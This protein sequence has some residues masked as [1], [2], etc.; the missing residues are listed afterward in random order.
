M[1]RIALPNKGS[2]SEATVNM[3]SEAGYHCRRS[4]RELMLTD[5]ENELEFIFLRPRDIAIYVNSGILDLGITGRDLYLDSETSVHELLSLGF[6][7]STFRYAI[8]TA[9]TL[10]P[11][12]FHGLRI[13]TSYPNLVRQDMKR[14]SVDT[15]VIELDG[16]VEISI[17]LGVAD[18][19]ADVVE[20]GRTLKE[21]GLKVVGEPV[22]KSEAVV[23]ARAQKTEQDDQVQTF[24]KR[25]QGI[26]VAR[27][28]VM[29][30]YDIPRNLLEKGC[31][32]TPGIESPT[33]APLNDPKWI[34]VKAMSLRKGI[35]N[36]MDQLADLGAKGILVT[37]IRTCRI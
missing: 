5:L 29:I 23:I 7:K 27:D 13:A 37:E 24:L 19:I 15:S 36:I 11:D 18:A 10:T 2:L 21:A 16:A 32:I 8:P 1:L 9:S 35:N 4:S 31:L 33:I 26:V 3:L 28:Y 17:R 34:A 25:L 20:S 6:G 14:R 30:E 22:L 12:E